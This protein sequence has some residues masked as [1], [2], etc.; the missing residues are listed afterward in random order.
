MRNL[1]RNIK[2]NYLNLI[3]LLN[4]YENFLISITDKHIPNE[5]AAQ[6][7]FDSIEKLKKEASSESLERISFDIKSLEWICKSRLEE[8][9][10]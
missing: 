10:N 7:I 1:K 4:A 6:T 2:M 5:R 8:N 9:N 3:D